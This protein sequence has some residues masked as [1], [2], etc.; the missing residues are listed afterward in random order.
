M[1]VYPHG[2]F[3]VLWNALGGRG[4]LPAKG[5]RAG[6]RARLALLATL[7][8]GLSPRDLPDHDAVDAAAA[9]LVAALRR[10]GLARSVGTIRG[11]GR[12]WLPDGAAIATLARAC[13]P[14]PARA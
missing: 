13:P 1:E 8:P 12:I 11:G 3:V 9:A 10:L 2:A 7:V 5:T 4:G 14:P 6:R